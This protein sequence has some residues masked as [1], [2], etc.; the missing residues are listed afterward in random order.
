MAQVSKYPIAQDVYKRIFEILFG[1]IVDMRTSKEVESFFNDFLSPTEKIMLAKRLSIAVLLGKG[2]TYQDIKKI[3]RVSQT[4]VASVN[5][6]LK[7]VG[8]GYKKVVAK[9]IAG[10]K[11]D[12][13]WQKLDDLLS[14]TIPPKGRNWYY[15]RKERE[16][17]K[18]RR[19]KPF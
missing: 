5:I 10:E 18:W 4:T 16:N 15:W 11:R 3:L 2:Y 8:Q 12:E 9:I 17:E 13:F 1:T 7:F 6:A 14:E 19:K